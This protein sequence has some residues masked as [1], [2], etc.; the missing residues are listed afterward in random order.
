MVRRLVSLCTHMKGE[1]EREIKG[2]RKVGEKRCNGRQDW[3]RQ[4]PVGEK[5]PAPRFES[6]STEKRKKGSDG[7][8]C[9]AIIGV[10][11]VVCSLLVV[12]R[13]VWVFSVGVDVEFIF[14]KRRGEGFSWYT[15]S[16]ECP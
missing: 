5:L 12:L 15:C 6:I 3:V 11:V 2:I 1:G 10:L 14:K 13:L 7:G 4:N 16:R 9:L 8:W